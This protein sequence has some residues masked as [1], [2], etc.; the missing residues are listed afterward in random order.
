MYDHSAAGGVSLGLDSV[1]LNAHE[2]S[3]LATIS[4]EGVETGHAGSQAQAPHNSDA[5]DFLSGNV[6]GVFATCGTGR[7]ISSSIIST[8]CDDG[9][10]CLLWGRGRRRIHGSGSH[11]HWLSVHDIY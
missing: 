11:H 6:S 5:A 7:S 4:A 1:T 8:D 9:G 10:A 3:V 2:L